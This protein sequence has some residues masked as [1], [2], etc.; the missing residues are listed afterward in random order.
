MLHFIALIILA[1][2]VIAQK[3]KAK[4][5]LSKPYIPELK[6]L[7]PAQASASESRAAVSDPDYRES[8][9]KRRGTRDGPLRHFQRWT[10]TENHQAIAV[11]EAGLKAGVFVTHMQPREAIGLN[12]CQL[13]H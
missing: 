10:A 4:G 8:F 11:R 12:N 7:N 13:S 1:V 6:A 9:T 5:G 2:S 3:H